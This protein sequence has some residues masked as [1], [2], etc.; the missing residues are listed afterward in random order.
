LDE[1]KQHILPVTRRL[2]RI[3][4]RKISNGLWN[5][6]AAHQCSFSQESLERF[7]DYAK[8]TWSVLRDEC[9]KQKF[10][11]EI[12]Q[13]MRDVVV[14]NELLAGGELDGERKSWIGAA[15]CQI[16]SGYGNVI[17]IDLRGLG[18]IV[19]KEF[20]DV[21]YKLYKQVSEALRQTPL[22]QDALLASLKE[23]LK[24]S[25][26]NGVA[27]AAAPTAVGAG[28]GAGSGMGGSGGAGSGVGAGC[29]AGSGAGAGQVSHV[30]R[31]PLVPQKPSLAAKV[32]TAFCKKLSDSRKM[33]VCVTS[34]IQRRELL[35]EINDEIQC[36]DLSAQEG[37]AIFTSG[38]I[39]MI[40]NK[41]LSGHQ[42]LYDT[43]GSFL[44]PF[45][46]DVAVVL[47]LDEN[48]LSENVTKKDGAKISLCDGLVSRN[49]SRYKNLKIVIIARDVAA[50]SSD[51][52]SLKGCYG[53]SVK[54][55]SGNDVN[56]M[57]DEVYSFVCPRSGK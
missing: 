34:V 31:A 36:V 4:P 47:I 48:D 40:S 22:A 19:S 28:C 44:S 21:L 52:D 1:F 25:I 16:E 54:L 9:P 17:G 8:R 51:F 55:V 23:T 2:L 24:P 53:N 50:P 49:L 39:N 3:D 46:V 41:S 56:A 45:S 13:L 32:T 10:L 18:G 35:R 30:R 38:N 37:F 42:V 12:K 5:W 15:C 43:V 27:A 33:H 11:Q 7:T 20:L 57:A 29:G 26:F 14:I 6:Y